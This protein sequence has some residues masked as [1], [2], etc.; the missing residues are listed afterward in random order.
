MS[1]DKSKTKFSKSSAGM[2][3]SSKQ[4]PS[5]GTYTDITSLSY[6][7]IARCSHYRPLINSW[8]TKRESQ[9]SIHLVD[10]VT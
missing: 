1:H 3:E 5:L 6:L 9:C 10:E 4:L 7:S 8:P 2:L